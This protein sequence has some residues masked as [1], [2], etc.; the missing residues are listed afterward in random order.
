MGI[1]Q[2]NLPLALRWRRTLK[3]K[4][5][6]AQKYPLVIT[7]LGGGNS[8]LDV[9]KNVSDAFLG[10]P[11]RNKWY[12]LFIKDG[13]NAKFYNSQLFELDKTKP[14]TETSA[15]YN[16]TEVMVAVPL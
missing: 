11:L 10:M 7:G 6:E 3:T 14:M 8:V 2:K 15:T 1:F 4:A 16:V 5:A 12:F 9:N 13:S